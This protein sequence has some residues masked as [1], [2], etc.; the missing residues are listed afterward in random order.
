MAAKPVEVSLEFAGGLRRAH[1]VGA[2]LNQVWINLIDNALDAVATGGHI[3]V[4]ARGESHRVIVEITDDGPGIPAEI[5]GR[6]VGPFFTTRGVGHGAGL[7]FDIVRRLVQR[8]D[9]AIDVESRPGQTTFRVVLPAE[10]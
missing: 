6:I 9:G 7:G 8:Q 10:R 2:E 5:L 4:T 3:A 1:A